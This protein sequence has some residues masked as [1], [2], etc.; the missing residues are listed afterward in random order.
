MTAFRNKGNASSPRPKEARTTA[1]AEF[2]DSSFHQL[3]TPLTYHNVCRTAIASIS[4]SHRPAMDMHSMF[5][6][7]Q[8]CP[9]HVQS[10]ISRRTTM[11]K[12]E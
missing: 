8:S 2:I 6:L 12:F 5:A 4:G 9:A 7:P 10:R 3:D 11:D 1:G